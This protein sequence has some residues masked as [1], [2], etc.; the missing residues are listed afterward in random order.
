[1]T[2]RLALI[3]CGGIARRHVLAMKELHERVR[4]DFGVTAVCDANQAAAQET[5]TLF[6]ELFGLRPGIYTDHQA[7]T[8]AGA[9][10]A[11]DLCLP[12]GLNHGIAIYCMEAGLDVL[13]EKPLGI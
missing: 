8:A 1:M 11:A 6:E 5:A 4:A 7:L 3:G 12:H 10:D 9:A 2:I 13:C